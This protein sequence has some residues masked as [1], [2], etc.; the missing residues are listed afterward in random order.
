MLSACLISSSE[1]QLSPLK[2]GVKSLW[3]ASAYSLQ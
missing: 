2:D 3:A 1:T